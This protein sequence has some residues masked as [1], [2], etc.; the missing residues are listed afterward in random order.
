MIDAI[1]TQINHITQIVSLLQ[2]KEALE[3][4]TECILKIKFSEMFDRI[5]LWNG[6]LAEFQSFPF[7]F[8]WILVYATGFSL[9]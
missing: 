6:C 1:V 7:I 9:T 3:F 5:H 4:L 2:R 8:V